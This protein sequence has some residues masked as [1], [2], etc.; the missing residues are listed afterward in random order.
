MTILVPLLS[1]LS[2]VLCYV[3]EKPRVCACYFVSVVQ[4]AVSFPVVQVAVSF[5]LL[6]FL[7]WWSRSDVHHC[8]TNRDPKFCPHPRRK[9]PASFRSALA[10]PA[11]PAMS[12]SL[13]SVQNEL[14]CPLSLDFLEDPV[15]VPC[16]GRAFSRAELKTHLSVSSHCPFC[17]R[18]IHAEFRSWDVNTAPKNVVL[19][20]LVESFKAKGSDGKPAVALD[21]V[22]PVVD[23]LA[24]AHDDTA[25]DA[26]RPEWTCHLTQLVGP[27]GEP[28]PV[29]HLQLDVSW[30]SFQPQ[31][32]L[33]VFAMDRSGS[34]AGRGF[35]AFLLCGGLAV[36]PL[37]GTRAFPATWSRFGFCSHCRVLSGLPVLDDDL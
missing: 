31:K 27:T 13:E 33:L 5:L 32:S 15:T 36:V 30:D 2:S 21:D 4:V 6:L 11:T 18:D 23:L 20:S 24:E 3:F 19:A 1:S 37:L 28:L 14:M 29:G 10:T 17:R 7:V 22:K 12:A 8:G 26:D 9:E 34:M 25:G 35:G 16:C